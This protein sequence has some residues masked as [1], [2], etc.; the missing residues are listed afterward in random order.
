L[1]PISST[2]QSA[3]VAYSRVPIASEGLLWE[4]TGRCAFTPATIRDSMRQTG[5]YRYTIAP[6]KPSALTRLDQ[7]FGLASELRV[8]FNFGF[9]PRNERVEILYFL[10]QSRS[11]FGNIKATKYDFVGRNVA[12]SGKSQLRWRHICD[13]SQMPVTCPSSLS[14]PW[15]LMYSYIDTEVRPKRSRLQPPVERATTELTG[16]CIPNASG[17]R[18]KRF[19]WLQARF[20]TH[21]VT[22]RYH[23]V[24]RASAEIIEVA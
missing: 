1:S 23:A 3:F 5:V 2:R 10:L 16:H 7:R 24:L 19:I 17:M 20:G 22:R 18:D 8:F 21:A 11:Y 4:L 14:S 15:Q 13:R 6:V 12:L 9:S